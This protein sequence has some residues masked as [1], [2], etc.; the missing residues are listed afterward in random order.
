MSVITPGTTFANGEQL[1]A[2][3]LNL[4]VQGASFSQN[5]VDNNSTILVGSAITVADGGI[6]S[7]KLDANAV[8]TSKILNGEVTKAK[9]ENVSAPLKVL[10]R[11]SA[12]AGAVEEVAVISDDELVGASATT[13]ATSASIKTYVDATAGGFTPSTYAGGESVTLPNGMIMKTGIVTAITSGTSVSFGAAFP[14]GVVSALACPNNGATLTQSSGFS[15]KAAVD[16]LTTSG[17]NV[18]CDGSAYWQA[19]GY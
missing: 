5:A 12:G 6:T 18:S 4:L 2:S 14:N 10:G 1:T 16:S 9:I 19:I 15:G 11:M 8:T 17:M 3:D 13:L 7:A